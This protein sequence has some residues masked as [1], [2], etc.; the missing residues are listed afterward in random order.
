MEVNG[1]LH[2]PVVLAPEETAHG[3]SCVGGFGGD[4][5]RSQSF[6]VEKKFL[7]SFRNR[8]P[9]PGAS[10]PYTSRYVCYTY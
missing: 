5:G 8:A 4:K 9:I 1:Q 7:A 2:E 6:G 10:S 3:I